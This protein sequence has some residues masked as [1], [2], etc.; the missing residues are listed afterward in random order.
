MMEFLGSLIGLALKPATEANAWL[1]IVVWAQVI[2]L[3]FTLIRLVAALCA[4]ASDLR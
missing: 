3:G 4:V 1:L 2:M